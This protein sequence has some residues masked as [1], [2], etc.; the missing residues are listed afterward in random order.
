MLKKESL[1]KRISGSLIGTLIS[2]LAQLATRKGLIACLFAVS[3]IGIVGVYSTFKKVEYLKEEL[4]DY[5]NQV[6][7]LKEREQNLKE[8]QKVL[9]ES[10]ESFHREITLVREEKNKFREELEHKEQR[11]LEELEVTAEGDSF[12]IDEQLSILR[13]VEMFKYYCATNP[14]NVKCQEN[15]K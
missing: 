12:Y 14:K 8:T 6:V 9:I 13:T 2:V 10:L 7:T 4:K 3:S 11:L 5:K 1:I 15:K